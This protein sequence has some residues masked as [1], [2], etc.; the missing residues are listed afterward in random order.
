MHVVLHDYVSTAVLQEVFP[1]GLDHVAV[2]GLLKGSHGL[3]HAGT[4][5]DI[6]DSQ[7][8]QDSQQD[9]GIATTHDDVALT[10]SELPD[11]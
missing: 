6:E 5:V 9:Q 4:H 3:E 10:Q 11:L 7:G 1:G 2:L 8:C